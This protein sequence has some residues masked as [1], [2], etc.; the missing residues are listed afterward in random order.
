MFWKVFGKIALAIVLM[1]LFNLIVSVPIGIVGALLVASQTGGELD[2][3]SLAVAL[4]G[5]PALST[6]SFALS[7]AAAIGAAALM[8]KAF[9]RDRAWRM[10][11][12]ESGRARKLGLGLLAGI[13]LIGAGFAVLLAFGAIRAEAVPA[14]RE[15]AALIGWNL[16]LFVTVGFSEEI[17]S[18]GYVYGLVRKHGGVVAAVAVSSV[19]FAL[20][21]A[22]NAAV[23]TNAFPMI[24]LTLAGVMLALLREATGGL[25][26]PIG[27]HISWNFAQGDIF[28]FAVSGIETASLFELSIAKPFLAGG[29]FGFEGS[30]VC[31]AITLAFCAALVYA[32]R[33]RNGAAND[34]MAGEQG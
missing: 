14:T 32:I 3:M 16:L 28:G 22:M 19:L 6:I 33:K 1:L 7:S 27:M 31:T 8:Y 18:R 9:E 4:Q 21:H 17:F 25:W 13:G 23:F 24:N 2:P 30:P 29:D 11:W 20:L 5:M 12:N 15:V 26:A 34:R 10:G